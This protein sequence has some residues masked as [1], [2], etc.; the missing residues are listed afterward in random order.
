VDGPSVYGYATASPMMR[1][2]STG[3]S[4]LAVPAL[5]CRIYPSLCASA[6]ATIIYGVWNGCYWVFRKGF[7]G[8]GGGG[9]DND[10]D[11]CEQQLSDDEEDCA[12]ST[13]DS[14]MPRAAKACHERANER[15]IVCRE[16][17]RGASKKVPP[18]W[19][20]GKDDEIWRNYGR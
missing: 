4:P 14:A 11:E 3:L 5:L 19:T 10:G 17:Q 9:G 8:G 1:V 20:K 2:D 12:R 15:F 6:G 16:N 18:R 7:S 13:K